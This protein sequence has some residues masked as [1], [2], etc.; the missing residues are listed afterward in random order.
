MPP[1]EDVREDIREVLKQQKLT[2]EI[3]E[4]D[5]GAADKADV[6]IYATSPRAPP[7]PPVVKRIDTKKAAEEGGTGG[8]EA[9]AE[10][11]PGGRNLSSLGVNP[12]CAGPQNIQALKGWPILRR[13]ATPFGG[14]GSV[15]TPPTWG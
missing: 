8:Q 15:V 7:L 14:L 9:A 11:P 13:P 6:V 4:V 10:G 1:L 5:P 3:A 2:Q 12:R